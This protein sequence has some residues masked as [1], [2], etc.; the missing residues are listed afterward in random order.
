MMVDN[1]VAD[2]TSGDEDVAWPAIAVCGYY[3]QSSTVLIASSVDSN[4]IKEKTINR[5]L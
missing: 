5:Y 2:T 4:Y 1:A 3:L